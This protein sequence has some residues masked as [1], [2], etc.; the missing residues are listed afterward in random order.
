MLL[1][2]NSF[3]KNQRDDEEMI[4]HSDFTSRQASKP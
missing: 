1:D 3:M 4:S 2:L